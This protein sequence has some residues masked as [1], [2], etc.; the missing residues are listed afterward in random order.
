[1]KKA[2]L[3]IAAS[4]LFSA[5][6]MA[7]ITFTNGNFETGTLDGWTINASGG[8]TPIVNQNGAGLTQVNSASNNPYWNQ[9]DHVATIVSNGVDART[10]TQMT[11]GG[12]KAVKVGDEQYWYGYAYQYHSVKQTA[13]VDG[14]DPGFLYFAWSAILEQSYHSGTDTPY[15]RVSI[16]NERTGLNIYDVAHYEGDSG[17]WTDRGGW[18]V[19]A[20]NTSL[21]GW[22]VEA[23]DLGQLGVQVGDSLTLEAIARDCNPTGHAMYVYLDG[24]GGVRPDPHNVPVPATLA[25]LGLGLGGLAAARRKA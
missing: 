14:S 10:G 17:F 16:K 8:D 19:N 21:D 20:G 24:F 23:L 7:G 11:Y 13:T 6:A 22:Q 18:F 3:A 4:A 12:A 2:L 5:N 1:M 15:F 25:L 9:P